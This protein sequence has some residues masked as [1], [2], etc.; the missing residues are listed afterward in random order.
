[1]EIRCPVSGAQVLGD[2]GSP[3]ENEQISLLSFIPIA[4][5]TPLEDGWGLSASP[6]DCPGLHPPDLCW[7][8][9]ILRAKSF[10]VHQH[11]WK[12]PKNIWALLVNQCNLF[13]IGFA[14]VAE[15]QGLVDPTWC[16]GRCQGCS[17]LSAPFTWGLSW[18]CPKGGSKPQN[19]SQA[20]LGAPAGQ[21]V[22]AVGFT[23]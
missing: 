1:M 14:V 11:P 18:P 4:K 7:Q 9:W 8:C 20:G 2:W 19:L 15:S 12:H 23:W 16:Q 21:L 3:A 5:K 6:W 17:H 13:F 22:G 10:Q